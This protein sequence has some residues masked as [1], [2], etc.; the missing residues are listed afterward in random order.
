[1]Q[2]FQCTHGLVLVE[3]GQVIAYDQFLEMSVHLI[4]N[5]VLIY[6]YF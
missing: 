6:V 1:M 4:L 2:Q 3:D 5:W